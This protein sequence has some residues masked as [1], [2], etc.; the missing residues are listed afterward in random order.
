MEMY[1]DRILDKLIILSKR[2]HEFLSWMEVARM[3][4]S[5]SQYKV[6]KFESQPLIRK[7]L[8][9]IT[10]NPL[11]AHTKIGNLFHAF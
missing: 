8:Y 6:N 4:N 5:H 1:S 9:R 3:A 2:L 7:S 11:K 10:M